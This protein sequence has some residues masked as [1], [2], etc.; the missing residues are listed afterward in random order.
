MQAFQVTHGLSFMRVLPRVAQ[1]IDQTTRRV[2]RGEA[3]SAFE[4]HAD[5]S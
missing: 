1:V 3:V 4:A 5:V 2:L